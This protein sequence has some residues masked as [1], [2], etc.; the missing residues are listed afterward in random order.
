MNGEKERIARQFNRLASEYDQVAVAQRR[1]AHRIMQI[2]EDKEVEPKEILE[3]GCGTGYLTQLLTERYPE[4]RFTV[5]DI[6][7]RMVAVARERTGRARDIQFVVEDVEEWSWRPD[8][9][10]L[11]VSNA[12][13]HWFSQPAASLRGMGAALKPGGFF[14]GSTFGPDTFQELGEIHRDLERTESLLLPWEHATLVNPGEWEGFLRS[15]GMVASS[16]VCWHRIDYP[17]SYHFLQAIRRMGVCYEVNSDHDV[18]IEPKLASEVMRRYDRA[19]RNRDGGIY[20]TYQLIQVF[21]HKPE[22][23]GADSE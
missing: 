10:D 1:M 18:G 20:A 23:V 4:A 2:L 9:F 6:A 17:N 7:D 3:I 8:Q 11:V 21:G 19:Y 22:A 12:V 15:A 14:I 13:L 5:V 16:Q